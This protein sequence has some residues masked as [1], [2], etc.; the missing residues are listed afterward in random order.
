MA[1]IVLKVN[2]NDGGALASLEKIEKITKQFSSSKI[3]ISIAY[4]DGGAVASLEKVEKQLQ[5]LQTSNVKISIDVSGIQD[6]TKANIKAL[7]SIA[8]VTNASAQLEKSQNKV[9]V[10]ANE[11]AKAQ[12]NA[13]A[14]ASKLAIEQ[15]RAAQAPARLA[16]AQERTTQAGIRLQTTQERTVQATSRLAIEQEKTIRSTQ[17]LAAEKEKTAR[18]TERVSKNTKE[19]T[20]QNNL[21]GDSLVNIAAKMAVWQIMGDL[22]SRPLQAMRDAVEILKEVD[23][24]L[25]EIRKVTDLSTQEIED[26]TDRAYET[27]SKYGIAVQS[28]LEGVAEF[29]RAGYGEASESL[30]ELATK[31][32][33]VGNVSA[34]SANQ[35]LL[36]VD[37][38]YKMKGNVEELNHVLDAANRIDNEYATSIEKITEGLGIVAPVAAQ[39]GVSVDELMASIGTI[40]AV[41]QR[42]GSETARALRALFLNI[43][44]DTKTEIEDGVTWTEEEIESLNDVLRKYVPEAVAAAEATGSIIN[45]MEA[46]AGMSEAFKE[47]LLTEQDLMAMVSDLGGKLRT[48][49][50]L[51]FI[52]NWDMYSKMLDKAAN[53]AGSADK[54]ISNAMDSWTRK[55]EILK[56]RWAEFVA[57]F[58][59]TDLIKGSLD[60]LINAIDSLD[61]GFLGLVA[62][63]GAVSAAMSLL[64]KAAQIDWIKNAALLIPN[65]A[66]SLLGMAAGS[67]AAASAFTF[68]TS[69]MLANPI[70]WA[71]S[72]AVAVW[73]IVKIIDATTVSLEEQREI[74]ENLTASV[75]NLKSEYESLYANENRTA[76]EENRLSL[77]QAQIE[78][79]E[80]L[81]R[82]EQQRL[83]TMEWGGEDTPQKGA[84]VG[85]VALGA[86]GG[87]TYN[88]QDELS[89]AISQYEELAEVSAKNIEQDN[90]LI[91]SRARL[92][93]EIASGVDALIKAKESGIA[94]S[95]SQEELLRT[96]SELLGIAKDSGAR[97]AEEALQELD[98]TV[99]KTE[100]DIHTFIEGLIKS[101]GA[102]GD[103]AEAIRS[104]VLKA[105]KE[106]SA[107]TE[108]TRVSIEQLSRSVSSFATIA[109]GLQEGYDL[110][111]KGQEE[112]AENGVVSLETIN[113]LIEAGLEDYLVGV[114]DGYVLVNGSLETYIESQRIE[115]ELALNEAVQ[116]AKQQI[117]AQDGVALAYDG[118]T[119]SILNAIRAQ[120]E[121]IRL[122]GIESASKDG[123][124]TRTESAK[125]DSGLKAYNDAIS[126]ITSK[127]QDL[128][129]FD[130]AVAT[131]GKTSEDA[132]RSASGAAKKAETAAD[133]AAEAWSKLSDVMEYALEQRKK[134]VDAATDA[135]DRQIDGLEALQDAADKQAD[136]E[137]N[138]LEDELERLRDSLDAQ[139]EALEANQDAEVDAKQAEIDAL[140]EARD[141]EQDQ[142]TLEEKRLAVEKARQ[143]LLNAQNERTV[144]YYN[145]E[146][147]QWEWQADQNKVQQAE[148]ALK[149]SEEDLAEFIEELAYQERIKEL[150]AERDR[151]KAFYDAEI[152]VIQ[153]RKA[154]LESQY[155]AEIEAAKKRQEAANAHYDSLI[156]QL[157]MQ[158]DAAQA[159]YDAFKARW[160]AIVDA[161]ERPT[162]DIYTILSQISGETMPHLQGVL[163]QVAALFSDLTGVSYSGSF[164]GSSSAG[165]TSYG[166][167]YGGS[168]IKQGQTSE[169]VRSIQQALISQGY[170]ISKATGYFGTETLDAVRRFQAAN[171]LRVDGIVGPDTWA[172]LFNNPIYNYT[173]GSQFATNMAQH[174]IMSS[175]IYPVQSPNTYTTNS[176][177]SV[178]SHDIYYN[179]NGLSIPAD[180][181]RG[182]T[183]GQLANEA[184]VL[185]LYTNSQ[186]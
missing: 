67:K 146:T 52:Q 69:S 30:A 143:N 60:L 38:A 4:D 125:I 128:E 184:R 12:A 165:G 155:E 46:V 144:R 182:M 131:L 89:N 57:S 138:R 170:D 41:T 42:S 109:N 176:S 84:G 142:L 148:E 92:K 47:G 15:T 133:K 186:Y 73:G 135:I 95:E 29:N 180:R 127:Q 93:E 145:E 77:L 58:L 108:E 11:A 166:T 33:I 50:L 48:T 154:A 113:A 105:L 153:S 88:R 64:Q 134:S 179:V 164:G 35:A 28:Y 81:L 178:D 6:L 54:E 53:S 111:A 174:G 44:G 22:I 181:A 169:T 137:V 119:E 79:E 126:N 118:T 114:S 94:L 132:G 120:R 21:L 116:A 51:A 19:A 151:I 172:S 24:Q 36:S 87:G 68:L 122:Q 121:Y 159:E 103:M 74:V 110:I 123:Y 183:M 63:I 149:D 85:I 2:Y 139:E 101:T 96:G 75:S 162:E 27:A 45:P 104:T 72:G 177:S 16:E 80:E 117:E 156:D 147:G 98:R 150:E 26:L 100:Q 152:G 157:E 129:D 158:K 7:N 13:S 76:S 43:M 65:L 99:I 124:V 17:K 173:S 175:G 10:S 141:I 168:L 55:T 20:K 56:N 49:Q 185:A 115:Y 107:S 3:A 62:T 59:D 61:G 161:Y 83:F 167:P 70:F 171:G 23:D 90:E 25:V 5:K 66:K 86:G 1:Q 32:Q 14:T 39:A 140:K 160:D 9:K 102:T 136:S 37:A 112:M 82:L 40:T 18:Q 163:G 31:L 97:I 34:E 130:R 78:A 106:T 91:E 8:R 71:A